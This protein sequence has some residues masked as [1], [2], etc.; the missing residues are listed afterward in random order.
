MQRLRASAVQRTKH[1]FRPGTMANRI[2]H[3]KVYIGFCCY[4]KSTD[5]PATHTTLMCFIEFLLRSMR[6]PASVR[7]CLASVRFAHAML[8]LDV[9]V[10]DHFQLRLHLRS[11]D[12]T[13]RH[14]IHQAP[15]ITQ[16][17]LH[18]LVS[19]AVSMGTQG[20][21]FAVLCVVAF[22]T[23]ARLSSLVP[24]S[25]AAFDP[26]RH[27]CR[28]DIT[29]HAPGFWI[30]VKWAKNMQT[31]GVS[32]AFPIA[33]THSPLCPLALLTH[34]LARVPTLASRQ[35]LFTLLSPGYGSMPHPLTIHRARV[36][37]RVVA[38]KA[39]LASLGY[40]F[41]SFRRGGCTL[42]FQ[43]GVA[44]PEIQRFGAWRSQAVECYLPTTTSRSAVATRL[45]APSP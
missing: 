19:T 41:H 17:H 14:F 10:F 6:A 7:N 25:V 3:L 35:P 44:T 23:W 12:L 18:L 45:A 15:P 26:T 37:L 31:S 40:T 42:A 22:Y 36:W 30:T 11:L 2:C 8:G 32:P 39:G 21:V 28:R 9:S 33:A 5:F 4:Y 24:P 29:I 13:V 27:P 16:A 1:A 20:L 38:Q 43:R 34:M